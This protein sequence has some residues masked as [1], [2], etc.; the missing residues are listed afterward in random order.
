MTRDVRTRQMDAAAMTRLMVAAAAGVVASVVTSL[1]SRGDWVPTVGWIVGAAIYLSWTWA[2]VRQMDSGQT[3][4]HATREDTSRP[5]S[6]L[7]LLVASV[8]SLLAVGLVLVQGGSVGAATHNVGAGLA[9]LSVTASWLVVHT[10]YALH[11]AR[12]YYTG[13]EGGIDFATGVPPSY[14][15]FAYVAFTIGMTYQVS[16]TTLRTPEIRGAALRH[17]LL[18]FLLGAVILG[19]TVNLVASLG[20]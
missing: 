8:A 4:R 12:L 17:A 10:V 6:D 2:V 11:Y 13:P 15:D 3:A 19:T 9:V 20:R 16:D 5:V 14:R 1:V 7:L 18:S